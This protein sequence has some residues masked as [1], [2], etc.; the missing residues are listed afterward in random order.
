MTIEEN[1]EPSQNLP[2]LC[3]QLASQEIIGKF[4]IPRSRKSDLP[5]G[6]LGSDDDSAA[7]LTDNRNFGR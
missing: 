4:S 6:L 2:L 5:G 3:R 7:P 1:R